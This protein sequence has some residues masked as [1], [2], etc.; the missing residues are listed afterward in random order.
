VAGGTGTRMGA[1]VPKQFLN[2]G[3]KS[4]LQH[5]LENVHA[6]IPEAKIILVLP[7]DQISYWEKIYPATS[8][9]YIPHIT[10][11]GGATRFHSVKAGL[12]V[13]DASEG[14]TA[15][16]DGVRP[17]VSKL[18]FD[19]LTKIALV[20]GNAIP[21]IPV[22]DS[23]RKIEGDN[24]FVVSREDYVLVQTPQVFQTALINQ[25][26]KQEYC[27]AF[28]DDATVVEKTGTKIRLV[29]GDR[30]NI[31]IT[32]ASDLVIAEAFIQEIKTACR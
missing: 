18:L 26:Y 2:I 10:A 11:S 4:I 16:H 17:V 9:G 27:S 14:L 13:I 12:D 19:R 29:E 28:T 8:S 5:C 24:S 30:N 15:I 32:L 1:S 31:K 20:H 23:M 6:L 3:N 21:A 7:A 22:N 25:A